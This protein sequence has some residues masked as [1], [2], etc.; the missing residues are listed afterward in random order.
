[1]NSRELK[2][3][4]RRIPVLGPGLVRTRIVLARMAFGGSGDYWERHYAREGS[5]GPGSAGHLAAFKADFLNE[6]V[7]RY[8]IQSVVEFGCGD[9]NQLALGRYPRY[10]GLD[11]SETALSLCEQRFRGDRTKEF[12][13]YIPNAFEPREV[14]SELGLSLDVIYHLVEDDVYTAYLAHLFAASSRYVVLYTSDADRL[15]MREI[16]AAHVRHRPV[17]RDIADR[18]P[19]WRLEQ[20]V[21]NRYEYDGDVSRTSFSDFYVYKAIVS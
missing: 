19:G 10:V 4:V 18:F 14:S 21:P 3:T 17:V 9:G 12:R 16:R 2:K 15:T 7:A 6:F 20:R 1:M 13:H 5:S 11:V 8:Q